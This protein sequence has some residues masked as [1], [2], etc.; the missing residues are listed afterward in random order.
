MKQR[1]VLLLQ[2]RGLRKGVLGGNRRWLAIW[3]AIA[4]WRI[5]SRFL[6]T[7]P[8]KE[9]FELKEGETLVISDLGVPYDSI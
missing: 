7:K 3:T 2:T 6:G 1:L 5:M 9:R 4:A 8:V